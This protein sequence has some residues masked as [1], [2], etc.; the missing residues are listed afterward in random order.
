MKLVSGDITV[1]PGAYVDLLAWNP[2][3]IPSHPFPVYSKI[4]KRK[5][6]ETV[7]EKM[8][9]DYCNEMGLSAFTF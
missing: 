6:V 5:Y 9:R 2:T 7:C 8:A 4:R 3:D 1:L